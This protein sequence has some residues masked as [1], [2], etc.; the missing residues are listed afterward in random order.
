V[1]RTSSFVVHE[2][3]SENT[4]GFELIVRATPQPQVRH[5]RLATASHRLDMIELQVLLRAAPVSVVAD[6][7]A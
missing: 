7:R 3:T 4:I 1:F 6:K 2:F 5:G